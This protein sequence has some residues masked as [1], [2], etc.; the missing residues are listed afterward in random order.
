[1][2]NLPIFLACFVRYVNADLE[3]ENRKVE[4]VGRKIQKRR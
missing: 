1:M 4:K 3:I 2:P